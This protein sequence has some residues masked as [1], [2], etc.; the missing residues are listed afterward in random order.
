[1]QAEASDLRSLYETLNEKFPEA[2]AALADGIV[3]LNA[4]TFEDCAAPQLVEDRDVDAEIRDTDDA[5]VETPRTDE[6]CDLT[7]LAEPSDMDATA[8]IGQAATLANDN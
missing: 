6:A 5:S 1:M 3:E 4:A 8:V 2:S 7:T